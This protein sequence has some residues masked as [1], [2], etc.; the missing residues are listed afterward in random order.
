[1]KQLDPVTF[2]VELGKLYE[3]SKEKGQVSVTMKRMNAR[4][5]RLANAVQK[6][7]PKG[8]EQVIDGTSDQYPTIVRATYKNTKFST[9]VAADDFHKFQNAYATVIRAYMDT[10]KKKDRSKKAKKTKSSK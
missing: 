9:T 6:S 5:L 1:M 10:L 2:T 7:L 8:G 3:Q 4:R